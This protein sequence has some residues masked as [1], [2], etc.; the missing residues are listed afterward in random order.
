M[1]AHPLLKNLAATYRNPF[2]QRMFSQLMRFSVLSDVVTDKDQIDRFFEHNKQET[3]IRR[4]PLF[5]LQW[6]M[7]KCVA[8]DLPV[9]EKLLEQGYREANEFERRTGKTFDRRQ[10]DD[11][12]SKF[13]MLRAEKTKRTG[14]DLFRDFKE[15]IELTNKILRQNDPQH[16]PFETIAEVV[17][18]YRVVGH[19]LDHGLKALIDNWLDQ[20]VIYAHKRIGVL[21]SAYQRDKAQSALDNVGS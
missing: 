7:A 19:H 4:M 13:L 8:G 18:A 20:L 5:W 14:A 21:A 15:A 17:Q 16:Y 10:L 3:Q 1:A 9:A 6:H 12:R 11:R 2:E